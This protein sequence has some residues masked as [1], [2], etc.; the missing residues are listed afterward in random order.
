MIAYVNV[1]KQ[2]SVVCIRGGGNLGSGVALRLHRAGL[3]VIISELAQPL[4]VRRTVSFA[5]AVY[6]GSITVEGC[7]ARRVF[8]PADTELAS[9]IMADGQIPVLV[10]P[11]GESVAHFQ[12]GVLVDARMIKRRITSAYYPVELSIGLGP[13]FIAGENCDA[14]IETNRAFSMGR[15]IWEGPAEADTSEPEA[16]AGRR[17]EGVLRAPADGI[18]VTRAEIG[19]HV[20]SGRIVAEVGGRPVTAA[21]KGILRGLIHPGLSVSKNTKIGDIDPRDDARLCRRVSDKSLA[22]GGGVL[23]AICSRF[24]VF[25][26]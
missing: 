4:A 10:D 1:L 9:Q 22:V 26:L 7:T 12:P 15:V 13:G 3:R 8:D 11:N 17:S 23:E 6:T 18:V 14:V 20:E 16:A 19:D 21:F 5:E 24:R 2:T 25:E